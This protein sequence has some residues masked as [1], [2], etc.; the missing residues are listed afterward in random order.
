MCFFA[1]PHHF[2]CFLFGFALPH[3]VCKVFCRVRG[4]LKVSSFHFTPRD[5][6]LLYFFGGLEEKNWILLK[7]RHSPKIV[8]LWVKDGEG[9]ASVLV[10]GPI[11]CAYSIALEILFI[12][13][14][15]NLANLT[16]LFFPAQNTSQ[17]VG[18]FV[19]SENGIFK[20][21]HFSC[22][23]KWEACVRPLYDVYDQD[24]D[25]LVSMEEF[26]GCQTILQNSLGLK[27]KVSL[28]AW[29]K[30]LKPQLMCESRWTE[31]DN[32]QKSSAQY[33]ATSS[34]A[35]DLT[36]NLKDVMNFDVYAGWTLPF[37]GCGNG[38]VKW[39]FQCKAVYVSCPSR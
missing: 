39:L 5:V 29:L 25:G 32:P 16:H 13:V 31:D 38:D 27:S 22:V 24:G 34:K 4:H 14:S 9:W 21:I 7:A 20:W 1:L 2:W 11:L 30:D 12:A 35:Y 28:E 15:T 36:S 33:P 8:F 18:V 23:S 17:T 3:P 6:F 19:E 37:C 26:I 10:V